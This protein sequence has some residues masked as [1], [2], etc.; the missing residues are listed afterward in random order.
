MKTISIS[1]CCSGKSA[2]PIERVRYLAPELALSHAN[3]FHT[4]IY[5][6]A[7]YK[8]AIDFKCALQRRGGESLYGVKVGGVRSPSPVFQGLQAVGTSIAPGN[9][10]TARSPVRSTV[11]SALTPGGL[12]GTSRFGATKPE[13]GYRCPEGY[14]YG[15]RF[16]DSRLSTCGKQLFDIPGAIGQAIG[17]AL[18]N[19]LTGGTGTATPGRRV[20]AL[21]VTGEIIQSRAP[22]IPKVSAANRGARRT[23]VDGIVGAMSGVD[24]PYTR[25]VRRD[26][27]VLEPVVSAGVL[28]TVPDNRDMEGATYITTA[29]SPDNIGVDELGLLSNTGIE[30]LTY[31]LSGG[32][33]LSIEK[34]RPL[35]VGERRKLGK[36]VNVAS[37]IQNEKDPASR[38]RYVASEMGDGIRYTE[39]FP[40]LSDPNEIVEVKLPE[41]GVKTLMRRWVF[42]SFYRKGKKKKRPIETDSTPDGTVPSPS[43]LID[44]L[45]GA[46]RHLN[47]NGSL[48]FI[49]PS[50][51]AEALKRSQMYKTGKIKNGVILHER[52]DGQTVFEIAPKERYEHLGAALSSELQRSMG[53]IAPKVRIAGKG[54]R[55]S[56][57]V[58]EAQDAMPNGSQSRSA[59]RETMSAEDM[60]GIAISDWLLDSYKRNPSNIAPVVVSGKMRAVASMNP[61]SGL[62]EG[63]STSNRKRLKVDFN[64]FF[65]E[66]QRNMYR[67]HFEK[68]QMQQRRKAV[69]LFEKLIDRAQEFDFKEIRQRLAIDGQLSSPEKMHLQIVEG[70]YKS[71]LDR[72]KSSRAMFLTTLGLK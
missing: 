47:S 46:V 35:T 8:K 14:Q 58:G 43:E 37:K 31:V 30:K 26:G 50:L 44:N 63:S 71:R 6:L 27:F 38:L 49:S 12:P 11:F 55:R 18:S 24:T 13:R 62:A 66:E 9:T 70:L 3:A 16:T 54:E 21:A 36:T 53:L 10:S 68:L 2:V 29:F 42:E 56:Y 61:M 51:R 60:L 7:D 72:L 59:A 25:M 4:P 22:Q 48:E 33:T 39:S 69:A 41:S 32:S 5:A 15:G 34:A 1:D 65:A 45:S 19:S 52:A 67:D 23:A 28:R 57:L 20:G 17:R 40:E 64:T